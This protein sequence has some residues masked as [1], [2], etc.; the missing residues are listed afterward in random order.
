MSTDCALATEIIEGPYTVRCN[1]GGTEQAMSIDVMKYVLPKFQI[2]LTLDRSFY[3]PGQKLKGTVQADY[4]FGKPVA[5]GTV[6]VVLSTTDVGPQG[7]KELE[8]TT[9]ASGKAEF[10]F[11]LPKRLVGRPQNNGDADVRVAVTVTDTA[12]Q[13]YSVAQSRVV[14]NQPVRIEVIPETGTLVRGVKNKVYLF[15]THADGTPAKTRIAVNGQDKE[16]TTSRLG[17]GTLEI[18]PDADTIGLTIRA[19]DQGDAGFVGRRHVKLACGK[20]GRDFLFRTDKAVYTG[21]ESVNVVALG[22]GVEPV[23][24][25]FIKDDQT[26]LT[27]VI[28]V[29]KGRGEFAFDLPAE[30]FGTLRLCAYRYGA[31]GL[32]VMK[33]RTIHVKPAT[34]LKIKAALDRKEYRPGQSAKLNLT[35]TDADGKPMTGAISLSAVDEAVYHVLRQRPGME[36]TFFQLEQ[37]L[38]EPV[39]AIYPSWNAF[40]DP[41]DD[42]PL[43][44][45]VEFE[46]AL[47]ALTTQSVASPNLPVRRGN[48]GRTEP[49]IPGDDAMEDVVDSP[50]DF[51]QQAGVVPV[52][53]ASS[54]FTLSESSYAAKVQR[55]AAERVTGLANVE[56]AWRWLAGFVT[57]GLLAAFAIFLTKAFLITGGVAACLGVVSISFYA[58][59]ENAQPQMFTEAS[60]AV[61][62]SAQ[63]D[64]MVF[65]AAGAEWMDD[66]MPPADAMFKGEGA[67][68][69]GDA[70]GD[71]PTEDL[72]RTALAKGLTDS[73][74]RV[75][76][77]FPETLLW[78]PEVITDDKGHATI[79]IELADSI[80]SWR[81]TASAVSGGGHLGAMQRPIRVFQP[82]FVDLNLPVALVRNDEVAVPVVVY[83]YLDEPQTVELELAADEWFELVDAD[84]AEGMFQRLELKPGEVRAT[85]YRVRAKQVGK[86]ALQVTARSGDIADA[87]RRE[88][89]IEPD[90]RM[91][92]QVVNGTL[93]E[94]ANIE[95]VVPP[96]AIPGSVKAIVKLYPSSFS[97]LVEGLDGIFRRPGGCFEQTSSTTYPNILALQYLRETGKSAPEVEAKARQFIHLGY[98]RLLG[99]EV[100]GGGFDW[101]GNPP[102]NV[103]LTAY[104]LME[105]IDMA[106]VHDVD[107]KLI[108]RTRQWLLNKRRPDGM[109]K[110]EI[111]MLNDGL[112]G[113]VQRGKNLDL[114]T[115]AYIA[116]AVFGEP[117][118]RPAG[119]V[120]LDYLLSHDPSSI[121]S[122]YV[123]AMV[124]NAIHAIDPAG[125]KAKP[126]VDRLVALAKTDEKG[127]LTWW[128][129]GQNSSTNFYGSGKSGN[130][131]VTALAIQAMLKTRQHAGVAKKALTWLIEQK[132]ANG[133]WQ[134]TQATVLALQ[135][136]ILGT[137]SPIGNETPRKID[138]A[139]DGNLVEAIDIPVDQAEVMQQI[140]LSQ[141]I[142]AAMQRLSI[143]ESSDTATGYQ[144][145]LRYHVPE[146]DA[147]PVG[148]DQPLAIE[149]AYDRTTLSVND[150]VT[151]T[152]K[153]KNNMSVA[154]P[155]VIVDLPI[156]SG[157]RLSR[158]ELDELKASKM[159]AK[160]QVNA[161]SAVIYLRGLAPGA[162]LELQYRLEATMPVK[163]TVPP[164]TVYEY[165]DPDK[166]ATTKPIEV[167]VGGKA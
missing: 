71:D 3:Q 59:L 156:P 100:P 12:G 152:A 69:D 1:M 22:G 112:A 40:A 117:A 108:N 98:Q 48:V 153:V 127:K 116:W 34:D 9:D 65:E 140:N 21:G 129:M 33:L 115:T 46:Q 6:K 120:T 143:S 75:R 121:E 92:E 54:P 10:E 47:F 102:A 2:G 161:R 30:L 86:H 163:L 39:Y 167:R 45:R 61:G 132:D 37:Q 106:K 122:P 26:V 52:A 131:E 74:V 157:F 111:G 44:E 76:K 43:A 77:W 165:Y 126:F 17:V 110:A 118:M 84:A 128:E 113:S 146:T 119:R 90:G 50:P 150:M 57:V 51:G 13:K 68:D 162:S 70:G 31:E 80:T 16:I 149:L 60:K 151:A 97:Q 58:F 154:A 42:M 66:A 158:T 20:P 133:T 159:I 15:T 134:S 144:V 29:N 99:F 107:P 138:I 24:L 14:T 78:R 105:F 147:P 96:N 35:L 109:W 4:F 88:I 85:S 73:P 166:R 164:A 82:F 81:L 142:T 64:G 49:G 32:P 8:L 136:L 79:N 130:V 72:S 5:E 93:G 94:P 103:T 145:M 25:D 23:F 124:A 11:V 56:T 148:D 38:L 89:D 104:G 155:M 62:I 87:L 114:S 160:Y 123:L 91:I 19:T 83:N 139:L 135:A 41:T 27:Q 95:L 67:N 7:L 137:S 63:A 53:F 141:R 36:R 28:D 125:G 55:V 101:F 18:T